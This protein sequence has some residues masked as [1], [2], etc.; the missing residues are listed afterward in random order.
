MVQSTILRNPI[1][2]HAI[3]RAEAKLDAIV[4]DEP[5]FSALAERARAFMRASGV[6]LAIEPHRSHPP[7]L[8]GEIEGERERLSVTFEERAQMPSF[9]WA[10]GQR[11]IRDQRYAGD[12]TQDAITDPKALAAIQRGLE[13]VMPVIREEPVLDIHDDVA[14]LVEAAAALRA[15]G[16]T[17]QM[18]VVYALNHEDTLPKTSLEIEYRDPETPIEF[19]G[20]PPFDAAPETLK[21]LLIAE[22]RART[23]WFGVTA[24]YTKTGEPRIERRGVLVAT[25]EGAAF[26]LDANDLN[27]IEDT[28]RTWLPIARRTWDSAHDRARALSCVMSIAGRFAYGI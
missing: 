2:A 25:P 18:V 24:H 21:A 11:S 1:F 28:R 9:A 23:A 22:R 6:P 26:A 13:A 12:G 14:C 19:G 10:W 15:G 8:S 17:D 20:D 3:A 7:H 16:H 27:T 5:E 4:A